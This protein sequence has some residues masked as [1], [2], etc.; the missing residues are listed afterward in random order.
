MW[1][2]RELMKER[3]GRKDRKKGK[4]GGE[5]ER[6]RDGVSGSPHPPI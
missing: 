4:I 2:E 1:K 5:K 3:K 6:G